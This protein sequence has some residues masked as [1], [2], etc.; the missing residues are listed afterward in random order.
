MSSAGAMP[1]L[2]SDDPGP[3]SELNAADL[4]ARLK[5]ATDERDS[6]TPTITATTTDLTTQE[7]ATTPAK[8]RVVPPTSSVIDGSLRRNFSWTFV[9]NVVYSACQAGI[10]MLLAKIGN[11]EMVGKYGLAMAIATPVLAL[12]SLQL[13]AVLTTDVKE[14]IPFGEYLGFRLATTL[15]SLLVITG[16]AVFSK[17]ESMLVITI[18]GISQG[19]EMLA[20]LY[21]GRMQFVDNM[22]RIAKSQI[23]R[24]VLGLVALAAGV[25]LTHGLLWGVI[26]LTVGRAAV[27][28]FYDMSK[29]V[30]LLP[31]ESVDTT[32]E[33]AILSAGTET[34][35]PRWTAAAQ[36]EL[37]RTSITLGVI[38]MLVSLL[39]NIPRYFLVGSMGER[40]LGM[41]T[42]TAFLVSTGNLFMTAL[43]Q[44]AFVRLA[45]LCGAGDV[46]GFNR[47]LIRLLG[48]ALLI[49]VGGVAVALIAGKFLLTLLYRPEYAEHTDL[50]A[51]MMVA[52]A[53][54]YVAAM[55][56][57]AVTSARSFKP[58][59]P[60]LAAAASAGAISSYFLI[61]AY[62]LLGAGFAVVTTSAVLCTGHGILLLR[63]RKNMA[64]AA[65]AASAA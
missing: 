37:F 22:D 58:Q 15:L 62:G 27:L 47:L 35:K 7:T 41:F 43:G 49:G 3:L 38:A 64:A 20:D 18:M 63:V 4:N 17:R 59:I 16:I 60:V 51:A 65:A 50:L 23:L 45:R 31:R 54:T 24:G 6:V 53:L 25:Y 56:A 42:A 52:G 14:K 33:H 1:P 8:V 13:R 61:H 34:L 39:P 46:A 48:I 36:S 28:L 19:I 57:S 21:W 55:L 29:R 26:G 44:A 11:P 10:L 5:G 2:G 30:Q 40:A 9:G 32:E 12:S